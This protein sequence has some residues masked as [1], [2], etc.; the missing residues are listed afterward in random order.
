MEEP[1]SEEDD[2]YKWARNNIDFDYY[3]ANGL[4]NHDDH[5][6]KPSVRLVA[7]AKLP[8][9]LIGIHNHN[10]VVVPDAEPVQVC[11]SGVH[12]S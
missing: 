4:F 6:P 5:N 11:K 1:D 3:I 12:F 2:P 9:G 8:F 7:K 10:H